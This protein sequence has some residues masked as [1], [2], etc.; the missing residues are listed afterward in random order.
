VVVHVIKGHAKAAARQ[1]ILTRGQ[2]RVIQN[3]AV[4][5]NRQTLW[6]T[7]SCELLQ[8]NLPQ[9]LDHNFE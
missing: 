5:H 2:F 6:L 1:G 7:L 3:L 8:E 4:G 9:D